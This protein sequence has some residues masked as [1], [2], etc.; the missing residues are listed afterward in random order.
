MLAV[1][2]ILGGMNYAFIMEQ[3]DDFTWK[4]VLAFNEAPQGTDHSEYIKWPLGQGQGKVVVAINPQDYSAFDTIVNAT[5]E[6]LRVDALGAAAPTIT[7]APTLAIDEYQ[8]LLLAITTDQPCGINIVGGAD[9]ANFEIVG[10]KYLRLIH[11]A[12][13]DAPHDADANN[14]FVVQVAA[15]SFGNGLESAPFTFKLTIA[16]LVKTGGAQLFTQTAD[17]T[18]AAWTPTG[19]GTRVNNSTDVLD[20]DGGNT[21][22]KLPQ[23]ATTSSHNITQTRTLTAGVQYFDAYKWHPDP[24]APF[25]TLRRTCGAAGSFVTTFD[26]RRGC[27]VASIGT[28]TPDRTFCIPLANGCFIIGH[29]FTAPVGAASGVGGPAVRQFSGPSTTEV[30]STAAAAYINEPSHM[31][32]KFKTH[33]PRTT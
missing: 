19:L 32:G 22:D 9:A 1:S 20:A 14:E 24:E 33:V 16:P 15:R 5:M 21:M 7:V 2:Q 3:Q 4:N 11:A 26:G 12:N 25:I 10:G 31:V 13:Y 6:F 23:S 30:G 17:L 8:D 28:L 18:N 27:F 29:I